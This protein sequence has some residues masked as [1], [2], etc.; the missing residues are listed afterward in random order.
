MAARRVK[1]GT[2]SRARRVESSIAKLSHP[3]LYGAVARE[4]LYRRLEE[5]RQH[6]VVWV[7]GPPGG[8]KTTLV[9]SYLQ[10]RRVPSV[11][12]QVDV[13][14]TD[15]SSF[16]FYLGRAAQPLAPSHAPLPLLTPEYLSDLDGF[17]RRFFRELMACLPSGSVLVLDNFQEVPKDAAFQDALMIGV[18]EIP[19]GRNL[20]L[21]SRGGPDA[22]HM[23]AVASGAI[24]E[25][26]W[27]ELRLS[28]EETEALCA[29]RQNLPDGVLPALHVSCDGWA[30]GLVLMLQRANLDSPPE[31]RIGLASREAV[32]DYFATTFFSE[33]PAQHQRT[34]LLISV[35][36][37]LS[38]TAASVVA[39]EATAPALLEELYRRHLFVQRVGMHEPVYRLHG[40]FHAFLQTR[41]CDLLTSHELNS[42]RARAAQVSENGGAIEQA[43]SLW[44]TCGQWSECARL[45]LTHAQKMFSEG[46]WQTLM[47]WIRALPPQILAETPWLTYWLGMCRFQTDQRGAREILSATFQRFET[48]GDELGQMLTAASILIGYYLEYSDWEQ[49]EPWIFCLGRLLERKPAFPSHEMEMTVYSGMLYGIAIRRPDHAL[50]PACIERTVALIE[51]ELQSNARMLA[52]LAITG[53]VACM[54]GDFSLFHRVRKSLLPLLDENNLT[55]LNR[56]AWHMTNG[57]KLSLSA[58]YE[59]TYAELERGAQLSARFNLPQLEFLCHAFTNMHAAGY[60]DLERARS[61]LQAMQ[62]VVNPARPLERYHLLLSEGAYETLNG[63][64][65]VA[66]QRHAESLKAAQ[67]VGAAAHR[68]VHYVFQ[69]GALVLATRVNEAQALAQEALRFARECQVPTWSACYVLVQAWCHYQE[70]N[71]SEGDR[72]LAQAIDAGDDG[73]YRYFRWLLQGCRH[74]LALALERGIRTESVRKIVKHFR[75]TAPDPSLE[76][77]PWT[78]RVHTL[79]RFEIEIDGEPL[80]YGRKTPRRLLSLL[81]YLIASG[82]RDVSEHRIADALW[83]D[84]EGDEG[85]Q[86]LKLSLHRLRNL[87]GDR[88]GTL[89]QFSGGK[90]SL[91]Q[92]YVWVDALCLAWA[93]ERAH[94]DRVADI[95]RAFY[96]GDFLAN[97][98]EEAWMLP[99]RARLRQWQAEASRAVSK[100]QSETEKT[101]PVG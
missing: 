28:L 40:L 92:E 71:L 25:I 32:F 49:A 44:R 56:A 74:L 9:A 13:G 29:T 22:R 35:M 38:A 16:F 12:Y 52:G 48:S 66:V 19:P 62:R 99:A 18:Q 72:T 4:R 27:P 20:I 90:V 57:A 50:L 55:E 41:A 26:S 60:L 91:N 33:L 10:D 30:A 61:S 5:L 58:E 36:P 39:D 96:R 100:E 7:S 88:D 101:S 68:L 89:I 86:R 81:Q 64:F 77:W 51:R 93:R 45:A 21:I 87:L 84:A 42:A 6:P 97:E 83:P 65:D 98:A 59:G 78:V 24:A 54:L 95:A 23:R 70:G 79:G 85:H 31:Q 69:C 63:R 14:D 67:T 15:L 3:R 80:R 94:P 82:G 37:T 76:H 1:N 2:V 17:T 43:F 53:P 47:D 75:Y 73:S 8:G 11:W 34:M 46:R